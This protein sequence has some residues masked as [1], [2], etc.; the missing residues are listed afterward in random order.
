MSNWY[1]LLS[2]AATTAITSIHRRFLG[3]VH[4]D[5]FSHRWAT[6]TLVMAA[7]YTYMYTFSRQETHAQTASY[8]LAR[9]AYSA[10][11]KIWA[12]TM[13]YPDEL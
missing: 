12:S 7:C 2:L 5:D 11:G 8:V 6:A 10:F 3:V 1:E 13:C 9:K 4:P